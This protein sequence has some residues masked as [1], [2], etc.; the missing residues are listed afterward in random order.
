MSGAP[1]EL[2]VLFVHAGAELYGADRILLELTAGLAQRGVVPCVVLPTPGPLHDELARASVPAGRRNLG[3]LRRRYFTL[4]GLLNR[5]RRIVSSTLHLRRVIRERGIDLVHSNTTAVLPGAFAALL[6]GV[7]H[8]WHV[9][10]ITTRPAWFAR[11]MA[12]L[13]GRL[14]DRVVFVSAA[15]RD[16]MGGLDPRVRRK[17]IVIHNGI[18]TTRATGGCVGVLRDECGWSRAQVLVGM[19]GRIN[20]WKGQR[21]LLESADLL[22]RRRQ[23]LRFLMVGGTFDGEGRLRDELLADIEGRGLAGV[24]A[25][26]DFRADIGNVLA[27]LDIFVLPS[28]E[29]D[30]FPTVVLEAMAAGKPVVAFRHGGVCEMV[31]EG[32]SGILCTPGSAAELADAIERLASAPDMRVAMGMAGRE[33]VDRLFT[34]AAFIDRFHALYREL[35][36]Q[37]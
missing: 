26:Q 23:D 35:V 10:E 13:V 9:H 32:R 24:V 2:G 29:P 5:L 33:R 27:D 14:S 36:A 4:P 7:P 22:A 25:V 18:D 21:K 6:C 15:T 8:V 30:P 11:A 20:W 1:A 34:R 12:W 17:G 28:T 37:R 16:H 31:E 3:V 19:V